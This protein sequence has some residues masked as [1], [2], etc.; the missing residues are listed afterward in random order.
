M[1][2]EQRLAIALG[3]LIEQAPP[4]GIRQRMEHLVEIH[5]CCLEGDDFSCNNFVA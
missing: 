1:E 5:G 4:R 2:F 3:Q